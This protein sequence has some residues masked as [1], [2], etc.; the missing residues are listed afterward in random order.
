MSDDKSLA[1]ALQ[2]VP[3]PS[4]SDWEREFVR[5]IA[6]KVLVRAFTLT[7]KQRA[8]ANSI[9]NRGSEE[10]GAAVATEQAAQGEPEEDTDF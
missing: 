10:A 1:L 7:P 3:E 2:Q 5:S 6:E 8:V 9:L 4:L